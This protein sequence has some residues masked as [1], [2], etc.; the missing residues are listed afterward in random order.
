MIDLSFA[1]LP[2]LERCMPQVENRRMLA[3]SRRQPLTSDA[4]AIEVA[5]H[6]G[7]V[8]RVRN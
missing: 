2:R 1:W 4:E 7:A 8:S 3:S 6:H 5:L